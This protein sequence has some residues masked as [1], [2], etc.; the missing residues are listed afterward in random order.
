MLSNFLYD[1]VEEDNIDYPLQL[2][3][4]DYIIH[5]EDDDLYAV[6]LLFVLTCLK[7]VCNCL[8]N[9]L[10]V[11]FSMLIMSF[12]WVIVIWRR[13]FNIWVWGTRI[14]VILFS[15]LNKLKIYGRMWTLSL[16]VLG[17]H[18][19]Q[20]SLNQ[21]CISCIVL[22]IWAEWCDSHR[23]TCGQMCNHIKMGTRLL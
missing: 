14:Q 7:C 4:I 19:I 10:T 21:N 5:G 13:W 23:F 12:S 18:A 16:Y 2:T 22:C 8:R 9:L 15:C 1:I 3:W 17:T 6:Q 11:P 20:W